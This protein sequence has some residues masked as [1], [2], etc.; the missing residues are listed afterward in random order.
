M[1]TGP[2]PERPDSLGCTR[3][4]SGWLGGCG[5]RPDSPLQRPRTQAS[6]AGDRNLR[7][8]PLLSTRLGPTHNLVLPCSTP[9]PGSPLEGTGSG[10]TP[11][12]G[13]QGS[14]HTPRVSHSQNT[15][16]AH[17]TVVKTRD[18][19]EEPQ[20]CCHGHCPAPASNPEEGTRCLRNQGSERSS[21]WLKTA[22][23]GHRDT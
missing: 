7:P 17:H 8:S 18:C 20:L 19:A 6:A 4:R 2:V 1:I 13:T 22:Q 12:S 3:R 16:H 14:D 15:D 21:T 9:G 23:H 10:P 11:Q 5:E